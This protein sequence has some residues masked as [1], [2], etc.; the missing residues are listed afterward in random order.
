MS[1]SKMSNTIIKG[2]DLKGKDVMSDILLS[3]VFFRNLI[4]LPTDVFQSCNL[5]EC[6]LILAL[7]AASYFHDYIQVSNHNKYPSRSNKWAII[8]KI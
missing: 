5:S 3:S 7:S 4:T 1:L 8:Q 2:V 6:C